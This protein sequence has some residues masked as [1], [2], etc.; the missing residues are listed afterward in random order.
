MWLKED[1]GG[2]KWIV[3]FYLVYTFIVVIK[4]SKKYEYLWMKWNSDNTDEVLYHWCREGSWIF[5]TT[6]CTTKEWRN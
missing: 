1:G 4:T 6:G 3:H 5:L 2:G